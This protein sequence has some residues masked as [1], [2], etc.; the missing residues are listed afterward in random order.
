M[1]Q[2]PKRR[3]VLRRPKL[4]KPIPP[5]PGRREGAC[6]ITDLEVGEEF[7]ITPDAYLYRVAFI[8]TSSHTAEVSSWDDR[9]VFKQHFPDEYPVYRR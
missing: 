9:C 3:M 6:S 2:D 8:K 5:I 7:Y 4:S 1:D